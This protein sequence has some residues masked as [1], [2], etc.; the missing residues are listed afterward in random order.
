MEQDPPAS[1]RYRLSAVVM[2]H[3]SRR[4]L[5]DRLRQ[6]CP[7]IHFEAV[8]DAD[9]APS[10]D[11]ALA[12]AL[13]AWRSVDPGATHHLVLQ[14]DVVLSPAFDE[15]LARAIDA[16]PAR[17]FSL[18]SEWGSKTAQT[19]RLAAFSGCGWAPVADPWLPAPAVLMPAGRARE[20]GDFLAARIAQGERRDAFL[21]LHFL[22]SVGEQA[23]VCV[24]NLVQHDD[25]PQP[26]LLPNGKVRGPRR[27]ACFSNDP[28]P[29][30]RWAEGVLRLP[31]N[32]P[33]HSPHDL[34][35]SICFDRDA[36]YGWRTEPVF[37]WFG[38]HGWSLDRLDAMFRQLVRDS[39]IEVS[40]QPVGY[41]SLKESV[42]GALATGWTVADAGNGRAGYP[43]VTSAV[44]LAALQTMAAGP[45]RRVLSNRLLLSLP[46]RVAPLL[47][48]AVTAGAAGRHET[49]G[50]DALADV[51]A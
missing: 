35:A 50:A 47:A 11:G 38:R 10:P 40:D 39:G 26:S 24:P 9:A 25:P 28:E 34:V 4:P 48:A 3:P 43:D 44:S 7:S 41:D 20:F 18:F 51:A 19:I 46:R 12:T 27:T 8:E 31:D 33:Y 49:T 22:E 36:A 32:L 13:R 21:L 29:P 6:S 5:L 42:L 37:A 45:F 15:K 1:S 14:D 2:T 17:S 30:P 16:D 23:M